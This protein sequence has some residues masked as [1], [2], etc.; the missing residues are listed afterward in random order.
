MAECREALVTFA[1]HQFGLLKQ[2]GG[3]TLRDHL[4]SVERQTGKTPDK[5]IPPD[6]PDAVGHLWEWFIDLDRARPS[7]GFGPSAISYAEI[8]AFARLTGAEPTPFEV[9]VLRALDREYL[10]TVVAWREAESKTAKKP[11]PK[12]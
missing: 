12:G 9:D 10:A 2:H 4:E 1:R 8:D 3:G 5:L 7:G 6:F 11:P